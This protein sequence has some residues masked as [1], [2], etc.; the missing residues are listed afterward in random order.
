MFEE[1]RKKPRAVKKLYA[2]WSAAGVTG[3]IASVWLL[4]IVVKFS[5]EVLL[6]TEN[7]AESAGAFSQFFEK[8]REEAAEIFKSGQSDEFDGE[9]AFATS[10]ASTGTT[11]SA[12]GQAVS[13]SSGRTVQIG[14]TS[15]SEIER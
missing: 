15:S 12:D 11:T 4:A 13:T 3:I 7:V 6:P 8:T 2:F 10:S 1:L 14:T 5:D 9:E